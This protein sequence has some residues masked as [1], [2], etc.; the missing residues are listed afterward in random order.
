[1]RFIVFTL[2]FSMLTVPR[3]AVASA[4]D[5]SEGL[6]KFVSKFD[7]QGPANH[8]LASIKPDLPAEAYA[9]LNERAHQAQ[10]K[11]SPSASKFGDDSL[12]IKFRGHMITER[13]LTPHSIELNGQTI[14][15]NDIDLATQW[16][17]VLA[18]LPKFDKSARASWMIDE[19]YAE[20]NAERLTGGVLLGT[21]AIGVATGAGTIVTGGLAA[22]AA[23]TGV[24]LVVMAGAYF[25]W[26]NGTCVGMG[27]E[28]FECLE[29]VDEAEHL[30][31]KNKKHM[32]LMSKQQ[33]V[34]CSSAKESEAAHK[35]AE[36]LSKLMNNDHEL[37]RKV[38][39]CR[40]TRN[41]LASCIRKLSL[42]AYYSCVNMH[43]LTNE[44]LPSYAR[45]S[46]Q[47]ELSPSSPPH[48]SKS[49]R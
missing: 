28:R 38:V 15:F 5:M 12:V 34:D 39:T 37:F 44:T 18:A 33:P 27:K 4:Q 8:A 25:V 17:K 49:K 45:S 21:G 11:D 2:L 41:E 9:Y 1:M 40:E 23:A 24:G 16:N 30:L 22:G 7:S 14:D 13:I 31:K 36:S 10:L 6:S 3:S 47:S 19:A 26:N 48:A 42:T 46:A 43:G 29:S 32:D 35:I 20:D